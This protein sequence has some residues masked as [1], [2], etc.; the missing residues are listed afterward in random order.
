V[1]RA[2]TPEGGR[3]SRDAARSREAILAAAERLYA[4][5]G[6]AATSLADI[7]VAAGLSRG[8]PSYFFGSKERLYLAV[9]ER[10]FEEREQATRQA[11]HPLVAWAEGDHDESLEIALGQAVAGYMEFLLR[12]P[13]FLVLVQREEL[14]GGERLRASPRE[15][16][17]IE[18]AFRALRAVAPERE[19]RSF[20][21]S[22]AVLVF[23]SLTFSP[24]GQRS[25]FMTSLDRDLEDP[26]VRRRHIEL[27]T[28]QLLHL[29]R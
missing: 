12:R 3:K 5:R 7:A 20:D 10:V 15:S 19:L 26:A 8:T 1:S 2:S 24:L 4:E 17:A 27:V 13:S 9:L 16:R 14:D 11:F 21:V 29:L 18:D 25:T 28:D 22:D 23:V 6:F